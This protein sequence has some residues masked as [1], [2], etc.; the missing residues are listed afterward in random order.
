MSTRTGRCF[1]ILTLLA[2]VTCAGTSAAGDGPVVVTRIKV[3]AATVG[4]IFPAGTEIRGMSASKLEGLIREAEV[5][6][7]RR[8]SSMGP[9]LLRAHH[10]A[11]W[12]GGL[13]VGRSEFVVATPSPGPGILPLVPWSPAITRDAEA[14]PRLVATPEFPAA[15][16]IEPDASGH[17]TFVVPWE[18]RHRPGS[19]GE[20]FALE[21][22]GHEPSSLILDLPARFTPEGPI[23]LRQGPEPGQ[24][25]DPSRQSWRFDG[26][27]GSSD[28]RLRVGRAAGDLRGPIVSGTTRLVFGEVSASWTANWSVSFARM[29]PRELRLRLDPGLGFVGVS[30]PGL[31]FYRIDEEASGAGLLALRFADEAEGDPTFTLR[32]S[33]AVPSEGDWPI[34]WA[35]PVDGTWGGGT[36]SVAVDATRVVRTCRERAGRRIS[37]PTGLQPPAGGMIL[38]FETTGP[39]SVADLTFHAPR[40]ET[41]VE[42]IGRLRLSDDPPR[43]EARMNWMAERQRPTELAFDIPPGWSVDRITIP[44]ESSSRLYH[45]ER[46][47]DGTNRVRIRPPP[48]VPAGF[49]IAVDLNA[50]AAASA[51]PGPNAFPRITPVGAIEDDQRWVA[52]PGPGVVLRPLGTRGL[53]WLDPF[54]WGDSIPGGSIAWRW[55]DPAGVGLLGREV[56]PAHIGGEIRLVAAI[57]PDMIDLEADL[58]FDDPADATGVIVLELTGL[59]P[60]SASWQFSDPV[61]GDASTVRPVAPAQLAKLG[62]EGTASA[63]ELLLPANR[64][65][66]LRFL[67]RCS[68]PVSGTVSI[69]LIQTAGTGDV[70]GSVVIRSS[71]E[72][73]VE[74]TTRNMDR[75]EPSIVTGTVDSASSTFR[76]IEAY[77]YDASSRSD[78]S[79]MIRVGRLQV[80]S[81]SAVVDEAVLSSRLGIDGEDRHQLV[82]RGTSI[83]PVEGGLPVAM[84]EASVLER[85]RR[86]GV[87]VTAFEAGSGDLILPHSRAMG[88][89]QSWTFCLDYRTRRRPGDPNLRPAVPRLRV[90]CRGFRW[91]LIPPPGLTA[92]VAAPGLIPADLATPTAVRTSWPHSWRWPVANPPPEPELP[93]VSLNE[94]KHPTLGTLLLHWDA[95]TLPVVIDRIALSRIGLGPSSDLRIHEAGPATPVPARVF[96]KKSGLDAVPTAGGFLITTLRE[97]E[98]ARSRLDSGGALATALFTAATRGC[99]SSDRFQSAARWQAES[100][101]QLTA[102]ESPDKD[103]DAGSRIWTFECGGWPGPEALVRLRVERDGEM[104][105]IIV[106]AGLL[107][108]AVAMRRMSNRV[109]AGVIALGLLA[110]AAA[111]YLGTSAAVRIARGA[112]AG[113]LAATSYGLG[114]SGFGFR[115]RRGTQPTSASDSARPGGL[116]SARRAAS[117]CALALASAGIASGEA[118]R[119]DDG[120]GSSILVLYPYDGPPD[121]DAVPGQALIREADYAR[122]VAMAGPTPVPTAVTASSAFHRVSWPIGG[123]ASIESRWTLRLDATPGVP[124]YWT[125]PIGV[126]RDLVASIDGVETT[127]E[128][129]PGGESAVAEIVGDGRHDLVVRRTIPGK[130]REFVEEF[131]LAVP[132]IACSRVIV[133]KADTIDR[134]DPQ[135]AR[136]HISSSDGAVEAELGPAVALEVRRTR[137]G[138]GLPGTTPRISGPVELMLLWDIEPAGDR[139]LARLTCRDPRGMRDI[140]IGLSPGA[141]IRSATHPSLVSS[142]GGDDPSRPVWTGRFDP[143]LAEG[144]TAE[145]DL[146]RPSGM[147]AADRGR[148]RRLPR[149]EPL[150]VKR[151]PAMLAMRRPGSWSGRLRPEPGV[152][153]L[154]EEAFSRT[155]GE[156]PPDE[157]TLAGSTRMAPGSPIVVEVGPAPETLGQRGDVRVAI[158]PGR[159]DWQY[160]GDINRSGNGPITIDMAVALGLVVTQ[161]S[162][163]GLIDWFQPGAGRLQLVLDG[164]RTG[165]IRI[166]VRG[167]L[168]PEMSGADGP[169]SGWSASF[170]W[171]A[172]TGAASAPGTLAVDGPMSTGVSEHPGLTRLPTD[173]TAAPAGRSDRQGHLEFR[174]TRPDASVS[175]SWAQEPPWVAATVRSELTAYPD[176]LDWNAEVRCE[177]GAGPCE[178][179]RYQVPAAWAA[180]AEVELEGSPAHPTAETRGGRT[181]WSIRPDRP[182]WGAATLRLRA[183]RPAPGMEAF[184]FPALMPLGRGSVDARWIVADMSGSDIAEASSTGL[185]T[186]E[187]GRVDEGHHPQIGT[188]KT[189]QLRRDDA[190]LTLRAAGPAP[191][192]RG[193]SVRLEDTTV[194]L[195]CD[196]RPIGLSQYTIGPGSNTFLELAMP[197]GLESVA[198]TVDGRPARIFRNPEGRRYIPIAGS[199]GSRVEVQW[200]GT[201]PSVGPDGAFGLPSPAGTRPAESTLKVNSARP[202]RIIR[203]ENGWSESSI[204]E[205]GLIRFEDLAS[206]IAGRLGRRGT[207]R[208]SVDGDTFRSLVEFELLSRELARS[209][210]SMRSGDQALMARLRSIR[211]GLEAELA[212]HEALNLGREARAY[213]AGPMTTS[214][215]T[216]PSISAVPSS[217]TQ[218]LLGRTEDFRLLSGIPSAMQQESIRWKTFQWDPKTRNR[219]L[220]WSVTVA[221]ALAIGWLLL[222]ERTQ[223]RR[224]LVLL[225]VGLSVALVASG[226]GPWLAL[227][228]W[229]AAIL[230]RWDLG[231]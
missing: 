46:R 14:L 178:L 42:I 78:P 15:F 90:P 149:V 177:L 190:T 133:E 141:V 7:T 206:S 108:A 48:S 180:A 56:V 168:P 70:R 205:N 146:W 191:N 74:S 229:S 51:G 119:S 43:I 188:R 212:G 93:P 196:G 176:R 65:K 41:S 28:L 132:P 114:C 101:P 163:D 82:F 81:A 120:S 128:I 20:A 4:S 59:H 179:L 69:P 185:K 88:P 98:L 84:P 45:V 57:R 164:L 121:P 122:L 126:A 124:G 36:A 143:P 5:A 85:V 83:G 107:G 52:I 26:P 73:R 118:Y 9:K 99:D 167:W 150:D 2:M 89:S 166:K 22:P 219:P 67:G 193:G 97:A 104:A 197:A 62:L 49:G 215:A 139:V 11:R 175:L 68:A 154:S 230:G 24:G 224:W 189:Y 37:A 210:E 109:R 218:R 165:S 227:T 181:V 201:S 226:A 38:G 147:I 140:K 19:D 142:R 111:L 33:A 63:I 169:S 231:R 125:F 182:L 198:A 27:G 209:G 221:F 77:S 170:P 211:S 136:G 162:A 79:L 138:P 216:I 112:V 6:E 144:E 39:G 145:L 16:R 183:S 58:E 30:G 148:L 3:P 174:V 32:G 12:D 95:G 44:G 40:A 199:A 17:S 161:V 217:T 8:A 29:S 102:E 55:V 64:P 34:P 228:P 213:V 153:S 220:N 91:D 106:T 35:T 61:T 53:A 50:R 131:S 113:T 13:L 155:W 223:R 130:T 23:G 47:P 66:R 75:I 187:I 21:L 123:G 100:T 152:E 172:I 87:S 184:N 195:D 207:D 54:Q 60:G 158:G 194:L 31:L 157:L 200:Q 86:D 151:T 110:A 192:F 117:A 159:V 135:G 18:L 129:R 204:A 156:L 222:G 134:I 76:E 171:P 25:G 72:S 94:S 214:H 186:G 105:G 208:K 96:L 202:D 225:G 1:P 160:D 173:R 203:P 10:S 103:V 127:L 92:E 71:P 137:P 80:D 116:E 115:H